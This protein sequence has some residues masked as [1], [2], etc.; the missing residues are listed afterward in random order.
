[1]RIV[2]II[3][4][5][6]DLSHLCPART[7]RKSSNQVP[8][9]LLY[10]AAAAEAAGH[11]VVVFDNYVRGLAFQDVAAEV[12][13]FEPDCVGISAT[14]MNIWQ[15]YDLAALI[16]TERPDVVTVFGGPQPT[17]DPYSTIRRKGVDCVVRGE[18][19]RAFVELLAV[20]NQDRGAA[21]CVQ[22][23]LS[24]RSDGQVLEGPS[25]ALIPSLAGLSRPARHLVD[26]RQ[27]DRIASGL[28]THPVDVMATSRGC[29]FRCAFCSSAEY[30]NRKYR[31]RPAV[32][33]V[34]EMLYMME[35]YGTRG[36]YFREDNFTLSARHVLGICD[37]MESRG[38]D[39]VW[40]CES[41][42]DTLSRETMARMAD[43]GCRFIWCGVES[44]SQRI[45]DSVCKGIT[46]EQVLAFYRDARETGIRTGA[47]FMVGIPGETEKDVQ[48]SADLA[49]E[50]DA[51]YVGFLS[52][53]ALPGS[54]LYRRV[55]EEGLHCGGWETIRFVETQHLSHN[56]V[57]ALE[58][59]LNKR[60]RWH[61]VRRHPIRTISSAI[62]S[63]L[64]RRRRLT[65]ED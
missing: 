40:E 33:I 57:L 6:V 27:Y 42:V 47:S 7:L 59:E 36:F 55:C 18:G 23:V 50:I 44:G 15:G 52:Y 34:D 41:R 5:S 43:A 20:L 8:L 4:D 62:R 17:I 14:I 63:R 26:L 61:K 29:S 53:V 45:L 24:K 48:M 37:E 46:V 19:E 10:V 49:K 12:L 9:G 22:G 32:E 60:L 38:L 11:E 30:W 16:K 31:T 51:D 54:P 56:R 64:T 3:P 35:T 28:F 2:L 21:P 1:M 39:V 25:P 65:V 58:S 13:C